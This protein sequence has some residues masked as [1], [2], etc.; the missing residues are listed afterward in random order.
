MKKLLVFVHWL[1]MALVVA[2]EALNNRY[3]M[4]LLKMGLGFWVVL[5]TLFCLAAIGYASGAYTPQMINAA[6]NLTKPL[7]PRWWRH[8][9]KVIHCAVLFFLLLTGHWW[10]AA[11]FAWLWASAK[12]AN[13]AATVYLRSVKV[14]GT[15]AV[16]T[17][18]A[19]N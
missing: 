18:H 10:C 17:E 15:K 3:A 8:T 9:L 11:I 7:E 19:R 12:I 14:D 5:G 6:M 16:V 1:T 13:H 4:N 2:Q